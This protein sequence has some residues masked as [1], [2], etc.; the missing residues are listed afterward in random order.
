MK[1]NL[2]LS[3]IL[4][5]SF[6]FFV[7]PKA[8][9]YWEYSEEYYETYRPIRYYR[10]RRRRYRRRYRRF[11]RFHRRRHRRFR[12]FQ[13]IF[14]ISLSAG[15]HF[16][17]VYDSNPNYGQDSYAFTYG[18]VE[19]GVHYWIHPNLSFD[20]D[21]AGHFT[22]NGYANQGWGYVSFK[23][24]ARIRLGVFYLRGALDFAIGE[25][26]ERRKAFLFGFLFGA[27]MRIP[28]RHR[29]RFF[30]EVDYQ[31]LFSKAFY[32]PFYGQLGFEFLF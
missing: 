5:L 27:G 10:Y 28:L 12:R 29:T 23:P 20:L 19:G 24:G 6:L 7:P 16:V 31:Y 18:L 8:R 13:P 4:F 3:G 14:A 26:N 9:A 17:D 30:M 1:R 15:L 11:R 32:M 25:K 22:T 21:L 2:L